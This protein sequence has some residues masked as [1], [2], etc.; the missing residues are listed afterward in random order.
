MRIKAFGIF[1][2]FMICM[3]IFSDHTKSINVNL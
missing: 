1:L 3:I 2:A